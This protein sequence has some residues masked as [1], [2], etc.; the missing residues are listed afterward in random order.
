MHGNLKRW[1]KWSPYDSGVL[2]YWLTVLTCIHSN[3][4]VMSWRKVVCRRFFHFWLI[5]PNRN[6]DWHSIEYNFNWC[7]HHTLHL[8]KKTFPIFENLLKTLG[9]TTEVL[10]CL[11]IPL[12]S[13]RVDHLASCEKIVPRFQTSSGLLIRLNGFITVLFSIMRGWKIN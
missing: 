7:W 8:K 13:M 5:F 4:L 9:T 2:F 12:T 1:Y 10:S 6:Y 11:K 3:R